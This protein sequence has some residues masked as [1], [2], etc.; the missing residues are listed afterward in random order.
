[1]WVGHANYD[2]AH[3]AFIW[4]INDACPGHYMELFEPIDKVIF[5]TN[6]SRYVLDK[7]AKIVYENSLAVM[8]WTLQMNGVPKIR[9]GYPTWAQIEYAMYSKFIPTK[10]IM[11]RVDE[12]VNEHNVCN[13]TSMHIRTTDLATHMARKRQH[14]NLQ[15]YY[16]HVDSV[17][18][19][20]SVYLLTDNPTTQKLFLD[21]Y[22]SNRILVYRNIVD[23]SQQHPIR[24]R[25]NGRH[26]QLMHSNSESNIT[27]PDDHRYTSL[28]HT[29]IDILI[30]AHSRDF[31]PAMYSSLSDLVKL[32]SAIGKND[33]HWCK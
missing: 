9:F 17:P 28:Q 2:G 10:E 20:E 26:N 27:L 7:H 25:H 4:E 13:I 15:A 30:A 16:D 23:Q 18:V 33:R 22:G 3:L 8:T 6:S 19:N 12:Y 21:K 11:M 31:K 14:V 32:F 29:I 5:A 24:Y 1:M